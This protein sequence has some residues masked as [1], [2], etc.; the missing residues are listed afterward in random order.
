MYIFFFLDPF[1]PWLIFMVNCSFIVA[2]I[3]NV[4]HYMFVL[5]DKTCSP[6]VIVVLFIQISE[7][8]LSSSCLT[9]W[10]NASWRS[11]LAVLEIVKRH[12]DILDND[13]SSVLSDRRGDE[14][15]IQG[16][17]SK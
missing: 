15:F 1:L 12:D 6:Q 16:N 7:L 10:K 5:S 8:I 13:S 9:P 3:F 14:P 11:Q 4:L 2:K 17:R